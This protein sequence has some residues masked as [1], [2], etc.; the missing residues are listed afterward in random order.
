M[1]RFI[2]SMIIIFPVL[3]APPQNTPDTYGP[4]AI[5][6]TPSVLT[7]PYGEGAMVEVWVESGGHPLDTAQVFISYDS[8]KVWAY[9]VIAD[10][11][12]L[13]LLHSAWNN[14]QGIVALL[15]AGKAWTQPPSLWGAVNGTRFRLATVYFA[16]ITDVTNTPITVMRRKPLMLSGI[17]FRG[18]MMCDV[19]PY[20]PDWEEEEPPC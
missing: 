17:W 4:V 8:T 6:I 1:F 20:P 3:I 2:L 9:D 5:Y 13:Y 15:S 14:A 11:G 7:I 18:E 16:A 10:N 19:P 12:A